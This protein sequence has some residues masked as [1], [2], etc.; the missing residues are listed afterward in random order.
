MH[1]VDPGRYPLASS[2]KY[3]P[4][5]HSLADY[6]N[7]ITAGLGIKNLVL[8]QPS[9]YGT[10][11]SCLLDALRH[12][13]LQH[14]RGVVE[15][16]CDTITQE[17]LKEWH[18]LGVRGVR[19]NL[20]SVGRVLNEQ[21]LRTEL[22]RYADVV[23]PLNWVL[24]V[25]IPL[26]MASYLEKIVP[27]LGVKFCIDHFGH[28][29]LPAAVDSARPLD[30]N[31]LPGFRSLVNLVRGG[32]S[33]VKVSAPYRLTKDPE[34]RDLEPVAKAIFSAGGNRVVYAT[35]WPHTRFENIDARPFAETCLQWCS[36]EEGLA[37]KLFQTNAEELWDVPKG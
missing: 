16:D 26:Q 35:D 6:D 15:V 27:D 12:L 24:Q 30:P 31:A 10:D 1:V 17:Q 2:A 23:R 13:T 19:L 9:I 14:G 36:E 33:W 34:M 22:F 25:Y 20:K 32:H 37:Q 3:T 29:E 11:N 21:E 7:V 28:P 4:P 8:V 5:A 18:N